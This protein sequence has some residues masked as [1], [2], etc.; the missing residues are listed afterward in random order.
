MLFSVVDDR[1][2]LAYQEYRCV[3]GEDVEAGLRFL[4][5]AMVLAGHPKLKNDLRT[6]IGFG[7]VVEVTEAVDHEPVPL[8][9]GVGRFGY[10][11]LPSRPYWRADHEPPSGHE[12]YRAGNPEQCLP[13]RSHE[14][15]RSDRAQPKQKRQSSTPC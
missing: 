4:F 14:R 7:W 5:N 13:E 3:Y 8:N 12:P 2:G 6:E 1:S 10:V 11:R 15:E 9:F